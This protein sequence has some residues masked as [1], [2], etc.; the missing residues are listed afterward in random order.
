LSHP[1]LNPHF[2][3]TKFTVSAVE[4]FRPWGFFGA[5]TMPSYRYEWDTAEMEPHA[6]WK[7]NVKCSNIVFCIDI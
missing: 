5:E 1:T 2:C 7:D 6:A 4:L 3:G